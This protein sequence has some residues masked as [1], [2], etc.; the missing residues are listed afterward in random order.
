MTT[1]R[2][3]VPCGTCRAC[4]HGDAIVLHPE[5]GDDPAKFECEIQRHPLTGRPVPILKQRA[6]RSCVY[7]GP[8][9]CTI[10]DRA[11]VICRE[12]DCRRLFLR[13]SRAQRRVL[14]RTMGRDV[15]AAGR[16]RLQSLEVRP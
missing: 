10:H 14:S 9:G 12:F 5:H 1:L 3:S 8:D 13:L 16:A 2:S 4:C 7:L 11:P 6:D 15:L